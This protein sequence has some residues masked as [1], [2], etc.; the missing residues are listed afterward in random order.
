MLMNVNMKFV[1]MGLNVTILMVD[2]IANANWA[3][4]KFHPINITHPLN[5]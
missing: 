2:I 3:M 4:R 1:D 5:V